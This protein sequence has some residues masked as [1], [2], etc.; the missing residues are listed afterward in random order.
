VINEGVEACEIAAA[1][2]RMAG[3]RELQ[4]E[5]ST[6]RGKPSA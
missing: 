4:A 2:S 1:I 5:S 6:T 3:R